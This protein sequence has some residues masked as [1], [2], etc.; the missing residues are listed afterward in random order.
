MAGQ[1][2][3]LLVSSADA[4]SDQIAGETDRAPILNCDG[5]VDNADLAFRRHTWARVWHD[6]VPTRPM[7]G[8]DETIYR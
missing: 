3:S 6:V 8:A 4:A 5:I 7:T 2:G 1:D